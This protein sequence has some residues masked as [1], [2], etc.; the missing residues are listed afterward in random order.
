MR[1]AFHD[2][3]AS[4]FLFLAGSWYGN[5]KHEHRI[6]DARGSMLCLGILT[7]IIRARGTGAVGSP[8]YSGDRS[9]IGTTS[10]NRVLLF[11][12]LN[13]IQKLKIEGGR[14]IINVPVPR[15]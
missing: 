7:F 14:Q 3:I 6:L 12:L 5:A 4:R 9:F 13:S 11:E 10:N 15:L 8:I 2:R 1:L